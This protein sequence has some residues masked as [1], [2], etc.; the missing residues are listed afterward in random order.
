M[1]QV[2][3]VTAFLNGGIEEEIYITLPCAYYPS[4]ATYKLFKSLYGLKQSPRNCYKT[5]RN[6]LLSLGFTE[7]ES[8]PRIF[9]SGVGKDMVVIICYVD[10]LLI[11]I[12]SSEA[13]AQTKFVLGSKFSITDLSE[14][15]YF[16]GIKFEQASVGQVINLP[17]EAYLNRVLDRFNISDANLVS[18]RMTCDFTTNVE[19]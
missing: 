4:K 9:K 8:A 5:L 1:H 11:A 19:L 6:I 15:Y 7:L 13:I 17:Q 3:F 16:L 18:T 10:D 12:E 14:F 2:D